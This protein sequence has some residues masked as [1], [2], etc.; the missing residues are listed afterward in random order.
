[1]VLTAAPIPPV[2]QRPGLRAI[3][4]GEPDDLSPEAGGALLPRVEERGLAY[5]LY[6]SGSTGEPKGVMVEHRSLLN[7][8]SWADEVL[9]RDVERLP[10]LTRLGFDASLKQI[11]VPLLR[12]RPVWIVSRET[13]SRPLHLLAQLADEP[14]SGVNCVPSLWRTFLDEVEAAGQAPGVPGTLLLGGE[15]FD[16]DLL[17][18]SWAAFPGLRIWNLYGPTEATANATGGVIGSPEAVSLGR[19]VANASTYL[20]DP[21][22]RPVPPGVPGEIWIGGAGLARG[23]LGRPEL[24][25]DRFRPDPFGGAPGE[26][27]YRTGD[28]ARFLPG[29]R[30]E[31][32][33]RADDQVKLRGLRIEP[34]EIEAVLRQHPEVLEAAV[35]PRVDAPGE[36]GL[37]AY[38]VGRPDL[39]DL[40]RHL[41]ERLP[42]YMVPAVVLLDRLP[43]NANGKVDRRALQALASPARKGRGTPAAPRDEVEARLAGVWE[44]VLGTAPVGI[45][46]DFHE[47]GGHS[48]AAL[49]LMARIERAFGVRLPIS[50]LFEA[51]TVERLGAL[52]RRGSAAAARRSPLV[53]LRD[54]GDGRPLFLVHPI[55]GNVFCYRELAR[56]LGG[57]R[58]VYGLQAAHPSGPVSLETL[59]ASYL[60]RVREVQPAGPYLLGGWS[61]GGTVAYEMARRLRAEGEQ[62][63]MLALLD[64][65]SPASRRP[66]GE[67]SDEEVFAGLAR[68][69]AGLSGRRLNLD[70]E[71]LRGLSPEERLRE[72]QATGVLP[73]DLDLP[74][75]LELLELFQGHLAA[76]RDY[77]PRL[78]DGPIVLFRARG[79]LPPET[80]DPTLGWGALAR[81]VDLHLLEGHHYSILRGPEV[82]ALAAGLR[83]RLDAA[84]AAGRP[85]GTTGL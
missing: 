83:R 18:R 74:D 60:E 77:R 24:T 25:A 84:D 30:L 51:A 29:G 23:Y 81:E 61:M 45:H 1:V 15:G 39:E 10:L 12:G 79:S 80:V 31:F 70:P 20:L 2:F 85:G 36:P 17:R 44:E 4:V 63:E 62:V 48:L 57:D 26:R 52:L 66:A 56:A 41:R 3:D 35:V 40:R 69:L 5:V 28:L 38:L 82:E 37:T 32:L 34:R 46:D 11:F 59:A 50:A 42:D 14:A 67:L 21:F 53:R 13:V 47:L 73:P 65:G 71:R 75:L 22:L 19:P 6:T 58:P 55:G 72:L 64:T 78:Y 43:L 54:D 16:E 76:L 33:G 9:L 68:D 49:R 27:L 8:L 7:Y